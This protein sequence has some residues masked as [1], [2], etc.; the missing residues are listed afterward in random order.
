MLSSLNF[1]LYVYKMKTYLVTDDFSCLSIY[2][3]HSPVIYSCPNWCY[4]SSSKPMKIEV[5]SHFGALESIFHIQLHIK[6]SNSTLLQMLWCKE[7][8]WWKWIS[9]VKRYIIKCSCEVVRR[10][11]IKDR[12]GWRF[13][14][15]CLIVLPEFHI[16]V[17]IPL[18]HLWI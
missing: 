11:I 1:W 4:K 16:F 6:I 17:L 10:S 8:Y 2:Y 13:V 3:L 9:D 5:T 12:F 14:P 7:V 15:C 18:R